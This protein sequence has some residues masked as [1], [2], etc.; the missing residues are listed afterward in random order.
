[1]EGSTFTPKSAPFRFAY[2]SPAPGTPSPKLMNPMFSPQAK[3]ERNRS[4]ITTPCAPAGEPASRKFTNPQVSDHAYRALGET[5]LDCAAAATP[6]ASGDRAR[7]T[8]SGERT[9]FTGR[10]LRAR[11]SD[12]SFYF[13]SAFRRR[14][15]P[16]VALQCDDFPSHGRGSGARDN[17]KT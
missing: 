13:I 17:K 8:T 1:V 11:G 3:P 10:L 12:A 5:L 6:A 15:A 16:A 9:V 2:S 14:T 7:S 4:P